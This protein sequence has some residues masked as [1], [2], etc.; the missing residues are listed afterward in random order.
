MR[1][2]KKA[3][4]VRR[5]IHPR[6]KGRGFSRNSGKFCDSGRFP[7]VPLAPLAASFVAWL[8][9]PIWRLKSPT[10][11]RRLDMSPARTAK[12]FFGSLLEGRGGR[13]RWVDMDQL[14]G[15]M[16]TISIRCVFAQS[17]QITAM[18]PTSPSGHRCPVFLL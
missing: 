8:P 1:H 18:S 11:A 10:V 5:A 16:V 12:M 13:L 7:D 17:L 6:P 14:S 3:N 15:S 2:K 4:F 9:E